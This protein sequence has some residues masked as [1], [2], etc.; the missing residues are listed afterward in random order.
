M[1]HVLLSRTQRVHC[2]HRF[3]EEATAS[4]IF[5]PS[6]LCTGALRRVLGV[7]GKLE[8]LVTFTFTSA[9]L[10]FSFVNVL[11]HIKYIGLEMY[12]QVISKH[13]CVYRGRAAGRVAPGAP[14]RVGWGGPGG[15]CPPNNLAQG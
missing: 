10:H 14:G 2:C 7:W 11:H 4:E 15:D 6:D 5:R 12:M 1:S 9:F 13:T 8:L 3:V